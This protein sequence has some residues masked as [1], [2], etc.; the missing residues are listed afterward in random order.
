MTTSPVSPGRAGSPPRSN[1]TMYP[2]ATDV[3]ALVGIAL[4]RDPRELTRPVLVEHLAAERFLDPPAA[5]SSGSVCALD[6]MAL[7]TPIDPPGLTVVR[8]QIE[9]LGVAVDRASAS[10]RAISS[11]SSCRAIRLAHLEHRDEL[12]FAASRRHAPSAACDFDIPMVWC[13]SRTLGSPNAIAGPLLRAQRRRP[14]ELELGTIGVADERL[15]RRAAG[16]D[17]EDL[18]LV[19]VLAHDVE[20]EV[21]ACR[22]WSEA[23]AC[24]GRAWPRMSSRP[25]PQLLHAH[26][27]VRH[28]AVGVADEA[29]QLLVLQLAQSATGV[30]HCVLTQRLVVVLDVTRD[31]PVGAVERRHVTLPV[32]SARRGCAVRS[33]TGWR[34]K[35]CCA[36]VRVADCTRYSQNALARDRRTLFRRRRGCCPQKLVPCAAVLEQRLDLS[37][38]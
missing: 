15:A 32:R 23:A 24:A 22:S 10:M 19:V 37:Y 13:Q 2:S 38:E 29:A 34:R 9:R 28:V 27:V 3:M 26:A 30:S 6:M 36:D 14:A 16:R 4:V 35:N 11:S 7:S 1:S 12:A 8:E 17:L 20:V 18:I 33:S 5:C 25:Q 31:H 21:I